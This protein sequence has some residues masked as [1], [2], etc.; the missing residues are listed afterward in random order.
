MVKTIIYNEAFAHLRS[1]A[2]GTTEE[3][4]PLS[5][6]KHRRME[7][8]LSM[9]KNEENVYTPSTTYQLST[10]LQEKRRQ[11]IYNN[12]RHAIDTSVETLRL[13][14]L[15]IYNAEQLT[16][17]SLSI[18]GIIAL[19]QYLR[20]QG[21]KVDYIK[22]EAW[23][24]QL[25]LRHIASLLSSALF[26]IFNFER[27]ELPFLY[28]LCPEVKKTICEQL[29]N[30]PAGSAISRCFKL[31]HYSRLAAANIIWLKIRNS[32]NNIEE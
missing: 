4:I 8:Y 24:T 29:E 13:L 32:L 27:D 22:L 19:G 9:M 10:P 20:T 14:N 18:N 30:K 1:D 2:F 7:Q 11:L 6:W 28:K 23:I 17:G 5:P 31:A 26:Y 25:F 16:N 3:F 15:I 12:E 21:H